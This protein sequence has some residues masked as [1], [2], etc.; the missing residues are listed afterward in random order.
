MARGR[1]KLWLLTERVVLLERA[2]VYGR[3]MCALMWNTCWT[4]GTKGNGRINESNH[5][6]QFDLL[7]A[8]QQL[9]RRADYEEVM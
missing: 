5:R 8:A 2:G 9:E 6:E 1:S 3:G 4:F 7:R